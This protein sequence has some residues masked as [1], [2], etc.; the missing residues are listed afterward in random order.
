MP[1]E[2][3]SRLMLLWIAGIA[4]L[5]RRSRGRFVVF[6]D[7]RNFAEKSLFLL[8]FALILAGLGILSLLGRGGRRQHV[9]VARAKDPGEEALDTGSL[10]A[11][12]AG[13]GSGHESRRVSLRACGSCQPV[14]GFVQLHID[15]T[16]GLTE[17]LHVRKLRETD[18]FL[19]EIGPDR[20][21]GL[22][23]TQANIAVVVE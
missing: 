13:F 23:P 22:R 18:G 20:S 3:R 15:N 8:R 2:N 6:K 12:V 1:F 4:R 21:G 16:A 10:V 9:R 17:G 19:H 7:T 11:G 5:F 14:S